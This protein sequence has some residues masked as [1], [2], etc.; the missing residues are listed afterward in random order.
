MDC[1]TTAR[2]R[3]AVATD[4]AGILDAAYDA[5]EDMLAVL[6]RHQEDDGAAFAAFVLAAAAAG[7]GRDWIAAAE[8]LPSAAPRDPIGDLS[9]D[10]TV[11][12]VARAVAELSNELAD[13]LTAVAASTLSAGDRQHCQSAAVE[14][15]TITT[16]LGGA[17]S[18]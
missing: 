7:N 16:L 10:T 17:S 6:R 18:P 4:L 5:F 2:H 14:A 15:V 8:A 9:D 1:L 3:V 12:D 13:Q 11:V